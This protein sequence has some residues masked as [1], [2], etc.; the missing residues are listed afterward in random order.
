[1]NALIGIVHYYKGKSGKRL[2]H[3]GSSDDLGHSRSLG[4]GFAV[5]GRELDP[6]VLGLGKLVSNVHRLTSNINFRLTESYSLVFQDSQYGLL[7]RDSPN[8]VNQLLVCYLKSNHGLNC[9]SHRGQW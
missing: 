2:R 5:F 4:D 1:M 6:V 8:Y 7:E 3:R 9:T